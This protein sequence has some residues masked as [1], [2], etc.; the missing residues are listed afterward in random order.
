MQ[1]QA[2]AAEDMLGRRNSSELE[3]LLIA[4]H[5]RTA[6][7]MTLEDGEVLILGS[8]ATTP[9]GPLYSQFRSAICSRAMLRANLNL[10]LNLRDLSDM[11][12]R[13]GWLRFTT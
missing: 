3:C 12:F 10:M 7:H 2:F 9:A 13:F 8:L 11:F 1:S 5:F 6:D 4:S